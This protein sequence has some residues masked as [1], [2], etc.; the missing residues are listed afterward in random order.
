LAFEIPQPVPVIVIVPAVG[1]SVCDALTVS[2]PETPKFAVGCVDGVPAIVKPLN[3][4]VP[5]LVIVQPVPFNETVPPAGANDLPAAIVRTPVRLN[6]GDD[7]TDGVSEI[8]SPLSDTVPDVITFQLAVARVNVL[9]VIERLPPTMSESFTVKFFVV[10]TV[11]AMVTL[12]NVVPEANDNVCVDPFKRTRLVPGVKG[13]A[14]CQLP[15]SARFPLPIVMLAFRE[16]CRR[17]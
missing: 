12:F 11:L 8:V 6:V 13:P 3:V 14:F 15:A 7:C 1:A 17:R 4:N 5:P 16:D 9:A 2:R 10:L